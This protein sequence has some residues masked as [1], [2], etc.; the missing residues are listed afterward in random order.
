MDIVL[1]DTG[2][3]VT[4]NV[5]D[6]NGYAWFIDYTSDYIYWADSSKISRY[7]S[8]VSLLLLQLNSFMSNR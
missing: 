3:G 7:I 5:T 4:T 6:G 1:L 8:V 2:T